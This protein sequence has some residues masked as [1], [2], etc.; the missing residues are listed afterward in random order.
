[1][2][3]KRL[4]I[5]VVVFL[6]LFAS[7]LV[8][9]PAVHN[10]FLSWDDGIYVNQAW[11]LRSLSAATVRWAFTTAWMGNYLPL[12]WLSHVGDCQFWGLNPA[13]H[14]AASV[15][16][17]GVNAG[18][19]VALTWMLTGGTLSKVKERLAVAAGV[20]LAFGVH[21][22]Q[23]ESVAW[24]AERKNVL[25]GF[26]CLLCLC[27]YVRAVRDQS[28]G[29]SSSRNDSWWWAMTGLFGAAL[30]SK[31]MA[32]TLPL[33]MLAMDWFPLNRVIRLGWWRVVREKWLLWAMSA[34]LGVVTMFAQAQAGAVRSVDELG[35]HMRCLVALRGIVFYLWK[36]VWPAWLSPYYPLAG[37]ISLARAEFLAPAVAVAVVTMVCV[38]LWRRAPGFG[39]AWLGYLALVLPVSGLIQLASH[40]G[41][42][43]YMYLAMLPVTALVAT[44]GLWAW[45][46]FSAVG[47]TALIFLIGVE[48]LFLIVRTREQILIW[49]DDVTLWQA[50]RIPFPHSEQTNY[51]LS[52]ALFHQGRLAEARPY[53]EAAVRLCPGGA[54]DHGNLGL[55]LLQLRDD[56]RGHSHIAEAQA[57]KQQLAPALAH[58][59]TAVALAPENAFAHG[60]LGHV[61]LKLCH[62]DVAAAE[63]QEALRRDATLVVARYRL[64][65][66]YSRMGKLAEAY[67]TLRVAIAESP[68][69]AA[70]AA[71]DEDLAALRSHPQ[72]MERVRALLRR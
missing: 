48:C 13:G 5:A 10:G 8:H 22:L 19:V 43:R 72:F 26:F 3:P 58:A 20:G 36:L 56:A 63:L 52:R 53:A 38:L 9:W 51:Q 44:A 2:K 54:E 41:A 25:C 64:A 32:V 16:I 24:I 59:Q 21:P 69:F 1:M 15:V 33:V 67:E 30:L 37:G 7:V 34:A 47:R 39:A 57:L 61:N 66:A 11:E 12:T 65:C 35:I 71:R 70:I 17:H 18:L 46:R 28:S 62:Y 68:E 50:A 6:V 4:K 49:R 31:A 45:R 14:H 42:D 27:A 55:L 29:V 40:A 60:V 23:V